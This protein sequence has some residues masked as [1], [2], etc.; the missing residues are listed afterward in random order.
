VE[1]RT[2]VRQHQLPLIT[3]H[4]SPNPP[5][6]RYRSCDILAETMERVA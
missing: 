3:L 2:V 1:L 5:E 6:F 4:L